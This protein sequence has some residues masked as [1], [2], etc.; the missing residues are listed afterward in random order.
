MVVRWAAARGIYSRG[1]VCPLFYLSNI[2]DENWRVT[3]VCRDSMAS[4]FECY[5][6]IVRVAQMPT[7]VVELYSCIHMFFV[8]ESVWHDIH[9]R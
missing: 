4:R 9:E 2:V 3:R 6:V 8:I 7:A 1:L 5:A